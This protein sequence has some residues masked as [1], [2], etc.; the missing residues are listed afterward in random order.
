MLDPVE[1]PPC[2]CR[3]PLSG[4][5]ALKQLRPVLGQCVQECESFGRIC[6]KSLEIFQSRWPHFAINPVRVAGTGRVKFFNGLLNHACTVAAA[7]MKQGIG[8]CGR[9]KWITELIQELVALR[10]VRI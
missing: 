6:R 3:P 4:R 5:F 9:R 7:M 1:I 8:K 2:C 10:Y